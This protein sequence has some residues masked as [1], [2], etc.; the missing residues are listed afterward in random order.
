MNSKRS[1]SSDI[2][3]QPND[4]IEFIRTSTPVS[5]NPPSPASETHNYGETDIENEELLLSDCSFSELKELLKGLN[6]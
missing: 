2:D 3:T 6:R 4:E 1:P 5:P